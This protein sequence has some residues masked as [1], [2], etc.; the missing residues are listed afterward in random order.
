MLLDGWSNTCKGRRTL[1]APGTC[2]DECNILGNCSDNEYL[3]VDN[4]VNSKIVSVNNGV[5]CF[6]AN[7]DTYIKWINVKPNT[8]YFLTFQ[9]R[10]DPEVLTDLQFGILDSDGYRFKNY[11]TKREKSFYVHNLGLDQELTIKGQDG[12]LYGRYY[13]FF[14]GENNKI[15]FFVD[16]T[17]GK[18]YFEDLRIFEAVNATNTPKRTKSTVLNHCEDISICLDRNNIVSDIDSIFGNEKSRDFF[19]KKDDS[20]IYDSKN[21]M[22]YYFF[23]WLP[24][25]TNRVYT[26]SYKQKLLEKGDAVWGFI[27]EDSF[28]KRRWL[29][30]GPNRAMGQEK[31]VTDAFVIANGERIAFA[32]YAG[33]G[34]IQFSDFKV[35]L[36]GNGIE[37]L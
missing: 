33:S 2:L 27:V 19:V 6:T 9:G 16:G 5:I 15:G 7:G 35:F 34:K 18:V 29:S 37:K 11:H 24:I 28:G 31:T 26:F 3:L 14:T 36:F 17:V 10:T 20:F 32:L 8:I 13:S 4:S 23:A 1:F 12:E 30:Q 25:E 22:G 21:N